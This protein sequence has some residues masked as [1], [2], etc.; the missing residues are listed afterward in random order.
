MTIPERPDKQFTSAVC[1]SSDQASEHVSVAVLQ[2]L[3]REGKLSVDDEYL[4]AIR[5]QVASIPPPSPKNW[6]RARREA[7]EKIAAR[8]EA[9]DQIQDKGKRPAAEVA[10]SSKQREDTAEQQTTE[11]PHKRMSDHRGSRKHSNW[12]NTPWRGDH[13][14]SH[15]RGR[16]RSGGHWRGGPRSGGHWRG[17]A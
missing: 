9:K 15:W 1:A 4:V 10:E 12:R 11:T 3:K 16:P 17:G 5:E 7:E 6:V 14:G 8:N 13:S 2:W